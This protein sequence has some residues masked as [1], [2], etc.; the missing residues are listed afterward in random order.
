MPVRRDIPYNEGLFFITFTCYKWLPLIEQTNSYDLVY[1]WFDYLKKQDH[2]VTGY[3]IMPNHVHVMID[4]VSSPKKINTVVGDGKRFMA[5]EI[6]KRLKEANKTDIL[7]MLEKAVT[8]KSKD[9][10]KNHEVWEES[11]DWK[12]CETAEFAY[13]KLVYIHNNPCAGKWRLAADITKYEHSS[14]RFYISGK[15]AGYEVT[16]VEEIISTKWKDQ[17]PV[18]QRPAF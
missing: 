12:I 14:A 3:V 1:R 18:F 11:F 16:D 9:K 4:F 10:G 17:E 8:A 6:V 13:Q 15:H 5:Y 7:V 2:R